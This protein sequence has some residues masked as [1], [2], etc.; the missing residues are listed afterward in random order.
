MNNAYSKYRIF[1]QFLYMTRIP[2]HRNAAIL[3]A[4]TATGR[5]PVVVFSHGLGGSRNAYSHICGS[6]ASHGIVVMAADHRDS[7]APISYIRATDK[8]EA[9]T[10]GYQK[11]SHTPSPEVYQARDQQLKVRLWELGLLHDAIL[12]IDLGKCPENLDPNAIQKGKRTEIMNI[13][14]DQLDLHRPGSI[15]WAGHSFGATTMVQLMKSTYYGPPPAEKGEFDEALF[16]ASPSSNIA[17]QITSSSISLLLDMWCL[18]LRSPATNW[19]WEKPM[20]C[21]DLP[22]SPA[23]G[24]A[25]LTVLSEAF[26][27]WEGNLNDTKRAL[28]PKEPAPSSDL[29]WSPYF[30]Y[31]STAAHL[32]QSD[33]GILFPWLT[34][35]VLKTNEPERL[36]KLNVR[37]M[38]QVIRNNGFEIAGTGKKVMEEEDVELEETV[39][40][41]SNEDW[42][43]LAPDGDVRGWNYVTIEHLGEKH[44]EEDYKISSKEID[45]GQALGLED[46]K[47]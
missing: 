11:V 15:I 21:Y 3:P 14:K 32:S 29:K 45:E 24:K 31:P 5:W 25:L 26:I 34:S 13:F 8:T 10:V 4:P 19:L 17:H 30:F 2:V 39:D 42:R 28:S 40:S 44:V 6:L 46:D 1:P 27:K 36:L 41:Q 22:T 23:G 47:L 18:P 9:Q 20:P 16:E 43:I 33:F 35:T 38:L 12:K 7:S 37:A